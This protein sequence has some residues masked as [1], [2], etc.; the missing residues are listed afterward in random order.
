MQR[1]LA[2]SG[3]AVGMAILLRPGVNAQPGT[4][5]VLSV[6]RTAPVARPV[7]GRSAG[8]T[9]TTRPSVRI[10]AQPASPRLEFNP[11]KRRHLAKPSGPD[12][13]LAF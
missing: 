2:A 9:G 4:K 7:V 10:D 6:P 1:V 13:D 11:L 12:A 3:L 8:T 5:R